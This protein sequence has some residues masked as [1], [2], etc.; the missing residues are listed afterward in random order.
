MDSLYSYLIIW[1]CR[2]KHLIVCIYICNPVQKELFETVKGH[3]RL[4]LYMRVNI[5][6]DNIIFSYQP[7]KIINKKIKTHDPGHWREDK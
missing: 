7:A 1:S 5:S 6:G 3:V 2:C 4:I